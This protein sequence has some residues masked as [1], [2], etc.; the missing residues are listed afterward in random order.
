MTC[1]EQSS[2]GVCFLFFC[3]VELVSSQ[4][5]QITNACA[6]STSAGLLGTTF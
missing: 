1:F 4:A 3:P 6:V 5:L 2:S